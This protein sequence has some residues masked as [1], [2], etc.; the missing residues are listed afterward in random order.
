MH[1][2]VA[3]CF[4]GGIGCG[5]K[6]DD[7][8]AGARHDY[9]DTVQDNFMSGCTQS[10]SEAVCRCALDRIMETV[11]LADFAAYEAALVEEP[12]TPPPPAFLDAMERCG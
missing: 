8:L 3:A 7:P 11:P 2:L 12:G 4:L 10:A 1:A 6:A 5:D 9:P